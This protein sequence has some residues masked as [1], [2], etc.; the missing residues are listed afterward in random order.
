MRQ[1]R[2][3]F[4][5]SLI[6]A[7][8]ANVAQTRHFCNELYNAYMQQ[9]R[10]YSLGLLSNVYVTSYVFDLKTGGE[11]FRGGPYFKVE[12]TVRKIKV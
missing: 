4:C 6:Y 5:L 7:Y 9:N 1:R 11:T 8:Y 12:V 2:N 3:I 10:F